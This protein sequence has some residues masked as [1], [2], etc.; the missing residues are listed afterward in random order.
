MRML[1]QPR[2]S[3]DSPEALIEA[4]NAA[5]P[6]VQQGERA[7][8]KIGDRRVLL[9]SSRVDFMIVWEEVRSP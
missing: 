1:L 9:E 4:A 7:E 6:P 8:L 5:N 2:F 3:V